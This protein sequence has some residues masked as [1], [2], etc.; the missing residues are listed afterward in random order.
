LAESTSRSFGI[1]PVT[2]EALYQQSDFITFHTPL[3][4]ETKHLLNPDT[5]KLCKMGV[6]IINCA[7]GGIIDEEALLVALKE[8][9]VH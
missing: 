3:T 6:R 9:Q 1:E 8:G 5:I 2:L 4:P 7:R